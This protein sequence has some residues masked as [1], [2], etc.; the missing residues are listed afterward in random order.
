M[1]DIHSES[2]LMDNLLHHIRD[3][4]YCM[5][6]EGHIVMISDAGA[7]WL[8][9]NAPEEVIGK[10]DLDIFTDEHGR[11]AY[12]DEQRIMRTGEPLIGKVEKETWADGHETWVSTTKMPLYNTQGSI[13][14]TFGLSRDVTAKKQAELLASRYA[15][16]NRRLCNEME[17][18]LQMA[19]ELQK[20]FM[21]G[22]YPTFP[23]GVSPADSAARFYHLHHFTGAVGGDFCSVRKLSD[24]EAGILLCDVEGTGVRSA[25][26]TALLRAIV[27]DISLID[28]D[29]GR[30]LSRMNQVLQPIIHTGDQHLFSTACYIVLD[31]S[32]GTARYALAGHPV[33][34]LLRSDTRCAEWLTDDES[35]CGPALAVDVGLE[36]RTQERTLNPDDVVILYTDGL[37]GLKN[38]D[39]EE[40]GQTR[41]LEAA[42]HYRD[43][44]VSE[45]FPK[46]IEEISRHGVDGQ[47]NDDV[48]LAGCRFVKPLDT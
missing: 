29:P 4:I 9:F 37:Y 35:A 41:L 45:M 15:E 44:R 38:A 1:A 21:P 33:P 43:L 46:L 8:G 7:S 11:D 30:V 10:T 32:T 16:E 6:R 18:E 36:F 47:F 40:F 23:D 14:G 19:S 5:D 39:G 28:K 26:I 34:I 13:I 42:N 22:I 20:T 3:N 31:V 27:E 24:T 2:T 12:E 25:L 17:S 48:C